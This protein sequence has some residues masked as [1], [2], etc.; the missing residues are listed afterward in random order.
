[1]IALIKK[2]KGRIGEEQSITASDYNRFHMN[3]S[4]LIIIRDN[5]YHCRDIFMG[6]LL[7][8]WIIPT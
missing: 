2:K 7:H 3:L 6:V 5:V 4:A 8:Y 1:M